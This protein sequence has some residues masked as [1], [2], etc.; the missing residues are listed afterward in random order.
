MVTAEKTYP[1]INGNDYKVVV[2]DN[3]IQR[4]VKVYNY[5][6]R[7]SHDSSKL[8]KKSLYKKRFILFG[9]EKNID[10]K[11]LV[12][13]ALNEAVC[14]LEGKKEKEEDLKQALREGCSVVG[15]IHENTN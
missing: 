13:T 10:T 11:E 5:S 2:K 7:R 14:K 12:S 8:V 3:G 1:K 15:E 4:Y 9:R 6:R